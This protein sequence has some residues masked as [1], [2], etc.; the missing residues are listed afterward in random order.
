MIVAGW[1]AYI[2]GDLAQ[3]SGLPT[4]EERM[5]VYVENLNLDMRGLLFS[6]ILIGAVG[7]I[8]DVTMSVASAISEIK[9]ANPETNTAELIAA[10]MNVGRDIMGTMAILLFWPIPEERCPLCYCSWFMRWNPCA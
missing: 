8:M 7:A 2:F 5:L 6:G 3:L 4:E 10:G 9:R 1:L